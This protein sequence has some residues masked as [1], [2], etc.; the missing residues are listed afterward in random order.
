MSHDFLL[1]LGPHWALLTLGD[2]IRYAL[3]ATGMWW[4]L[5]IVL[6]RL[7]ARREIR[8]CSDSKK[9]GA[10]SEGGPCCHL[11]I[12]GSQIERPIFF[13]PLARWSPRPAFSLQ[14]CA[15]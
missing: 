9:G 4:L 10:G 12:Q 5:W 8:P 14:T 2:V 7:L 6:K 3:F 11:A 13:H 1:S 15:R